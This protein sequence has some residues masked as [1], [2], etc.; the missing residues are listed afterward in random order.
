MPEKH[1]WLMVAGG[2]LATLAI[3]W[4]FVVAIGP[5]HSSHPELQYHEAYTTRHCVMHQKIG[6]HTS[7]CA[8]WRTDRHPA[9]CDWA[10]VCDVRCNVWDKGQ[11]EK[12]Q[13][14][15]TYRNDIV[16]DPRCPIG[17]EATP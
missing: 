13:K 10:T 6:E 2:F 17:A 14:H 11:A 15:E 7:V 16:I 12:H 3:V 1:I 4:M 9:R 8:V 5:C